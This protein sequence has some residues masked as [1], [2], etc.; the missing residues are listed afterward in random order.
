MIF[1]KEKAMGGVLKNT[2]VSI[3][4]KIKNSAVRASVIAIYVKNILRNSV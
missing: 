1:I 4:S 3:Y 2:T